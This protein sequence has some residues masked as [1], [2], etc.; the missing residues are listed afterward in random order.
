L[1]FIS[2]EIFR[3]ASPFKGG[4]ILLSPLLANEDLYLP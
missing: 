1:E 3:E 2:W 4:I